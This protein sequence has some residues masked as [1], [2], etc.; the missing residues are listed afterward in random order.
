VIKNK[1]QRN[2]HEETAA[3]GHMRS[4]FCY[5]SVQ[6]NAWCRVVK[7]TENFFKKKLKDSFLKLHLREH[8]FWTKT[9]GYAIS[10]NRL[11]LLEYKKIARPSW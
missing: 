2:G 11:F 3:A 7:A 6:Q 1:T 9:I 10:Y 4:R 8:S 5:V